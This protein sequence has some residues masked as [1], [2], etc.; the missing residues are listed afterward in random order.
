MLCK[1]YSPKLY[2]TKFKI[3]CFPDVEAQL[4]QAEDERDQLT[5]LYDTLEEQK[6]NSDQ[7]RMR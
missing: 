2:T 7:V 3:N 1:T 6:Q 4:G 5:T